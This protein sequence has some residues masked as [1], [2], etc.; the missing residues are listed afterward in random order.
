MNNCTNQE[1]RSIQCS[2]ENCKH[3][4]SQ[5]NF[6]SLNCIRVGTNETNPTVPECTN[7]Q[8]FLMK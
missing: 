7:C 8:S 4:C 6:C 1:N 2:V 5:G 3:H